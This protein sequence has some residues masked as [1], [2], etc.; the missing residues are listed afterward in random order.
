MP[1]D[2]CATKGCDSPIRQMPE[3][4]VAV[5]RA[6]TVVHRHGPF[7]GR[8]ASP[9]MLVILAEGTEHSYYADEYVEALD[10]YPPRALLE[11]TARSIYGSN[12]AEV[13]LREDSLGIDDPLILRMLR[14]Y[15][16]RAFSAAPD[17][18]D[19]ETGANMIAARL[20]E[21][22]STLSGTPTVDRVRRLSTWQMRRLREITLGTGTKPTLADLAA[23][24]GLSSYQLIRALRLTTG[25]SPS[26]YV[27]DLTTSGGRRLLESESLE[28]EA[29]LQSA[30]ATMSAELAHRDRL[31]A[32]GD[33]TGRLSHELSNLLQPIKLS[34]EVMAELDDPV[35]LRDRA[36][37]IGRSI[38]RVQQ[39]LNDI[40]A[41]ARSGE[42]TRRE[43]ERL[44]LPAVLGEAVELVRTSLKPG[45]TLDAPT[46]WPDVD[47]VCTA[48]GLTQ[49]I[50]NICRNGFDAMGGAGRMRL[51]IDVTELTAQDTRATI[52]APGPYA[53]VSLTDEGPGIPVHIQPKLFEPFFT[54]KPRG[55]GTGL[56]LSIVYRML[57][58]WGG[59]VAVASQEGVGATFTLL[60]R[61]VGDRRDVGAEEV[62]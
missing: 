19:L 24:V 40:L 33:M 61:V 3:D 12:A 30:V 59:D 44:A 57:R 56:G 6:G 38:D 7:M 35:Q 54:T 15:M 9:G 11:E 55:K 8:R 49:V 32:I 37:A 43:P 22:H 17:A 41:F 42:T 48:E 4:I 31:G 18:L 27:H 36:S 45:Q 47:T 29:E 50:L 39:L 58:D 20:V 62:D 5:L 25:M 46:A 23:S 60:L 28:A 16:A 51:A 13:R 21:R 1:A 14:I 10:V 34:A 53:R 52:L 26:T 2:I